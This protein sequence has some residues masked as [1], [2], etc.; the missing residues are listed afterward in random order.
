MAP[1]LPCSEWHQNTSKVM[2]LVDVRPDNDGRI[3]VNVGEGRT[4]SL[5]IF[6]S[7][8]PEHGQ[9]LLELPLFDDVLQKDEWLPA[10]GGI[11][12]TLQKKTETMWPRLTSLKRDPGHVKVDWSKYKGDGDDDEKEENYDEYMRT[13]Y[14]VDSD[15]RGPGSADPPPILGGRRPG[16]HY[17]QDE[18]ELKEVEDYDDEAAALGEAEASDDSDNEVAEVKD[19]AA[20]STGVEGGEASVDKAERPMRCK[21][22][23]RWWLGLFRGL[24]LCAWMSPVSVPV[25]SYAL[26]MGDGSPGIEA[27]IY[28]IVCLL[29]V[30]LGF[31]DLLISLAGASRCE[32]P[33]FAAL[34]CF[35]KRSFVCMSFL[36]F[37]AQYGGGR[38]VF[39]DARP[40][41]TILMIAAWFVRKVRMYAED[42]LDLLIIC[43]LE[44]EGL[45]ST[46]HA[47][48]PPALGY[49]YFEAAVEVTCITTYLYLLPPGTN[50]LGQEE[51]IFV[52]AAVLS[53]NA[54]SNLV[55]YFS[56]RSHARASLLDAGKQEPAP[57]KETKLD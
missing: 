3:E 38:G 18:L 57:Q 43:A 17:E 51:P 16:E 12:V 30:L 19:V 52:W 26:G 44:K 48:A 20:K 8:A 13:R 27:Q 53:V 45:P 39:T 33:R 36:M 28:P 9:R 2:I 6:G 40:C 47:R 42:V 55:A 32:G 25:S 22:F 49:F 7:N 5:T 34:S 1:G 54:L 35:C 10:A 56:L 24:E 4:L 29:V 11:R 21:T 50:L 23:R 41:M 31:F 15:W 46:L 37:E 14:G